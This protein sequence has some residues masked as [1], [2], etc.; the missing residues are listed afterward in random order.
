MIVCHCQRVSD[1]EI[2]KSINEG[3]S[4]IFDVGLECCAG[5]NCGGCHSEIQSLIN[6]HEKRQCK[7]YDSVIKL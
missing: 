3:A 6:I 2:R 1:R 4:T 5:I 7:T